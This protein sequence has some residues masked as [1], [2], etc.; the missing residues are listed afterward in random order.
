MALEPLGGEVGVV[1]EDLPE[2]YATAEGSGLEAE[3]AR[4]PMVSLKLCM[5]LVTPLTFSGV[6]TFPLCL[7]GFEWTFCHRSSQPLLV[8]T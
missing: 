6:N 1:W 8:Q 4:L 3:K 2:N 7:C 5:N